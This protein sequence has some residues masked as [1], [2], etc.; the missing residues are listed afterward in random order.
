MAL[1]AFA[2]R[3]FSLNP[4]IREA[5][6]RMRRRRVLV[7]VV[8]VALAGAAAGTALALRG[9]GA[10]RYNLGGPF[11]VTR[12][13]VQHIGS[14]P[15]VLNGGFAGGG[16]SG[17]FGDGGDGPKG[18]SLG[19]INHRHYSQ[20]FGIQNRSHAP[21]TLVSAKG[22]N[23]SPQIVDLVA[24]QLRLSPPLKP[25]PTVPNYGYSGMDLVY[26]HWS[27]AP[28]RAV[29]LPPGRIAT[30]QSNYLMR[31]CAALASGR[32]IVVPGS[33]VLHYRALG[34]MHEK[35][36]PLPS[37]RFVLVAGPTKRRCAPVGGSVSVVTADTG[38]SAARQAAPSCH[39]MSHTSWGVCTVAG[40][41]WDCGST[42]GPGSPYLE[43]CWQPHKKSHWFRVRWNPPTLSSKAIGGVRFGLP[44]KEVVTRLS[45]L[46]GTRA[47]N[48]P[49]NPACGPGFTEIDWLR[50]YVELR[51]GRLTGF[52]YIA[53]GWPPTSD[54]KH[55]EAADPW[56]LVTTRGIT[57]GSTL[58]QARA[59]Y[60]HL[61]PVGTNRWQTPD[62]LILYDNARRYPDPPSSRITE[63]K[64]GTCGD[65]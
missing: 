11:R 62:G 1:S 30:V 50:L 10:P 40:V 54:G 8:V 42:A 20:A 13:P 61:R 33:L 59:A 32:K 24:I 16:E 28:T 49:A 44:R 63:I 4:L 38:C 7:A 26:K 53:N 64:Y 21:V 46:L 52:R 37:Q 19:C 31:N 36:I 48:P 35:M 27:A 25:P 3:P 39:P 51:H 17:L 9:P 55:L 12:P 22:A 2:R 6:R 41:L 34:L 45:E 15:F 43:T 23:P 18:T 60:G 65:F 57:L 56:R 14:G 5:K 29:T 47:T 58:A